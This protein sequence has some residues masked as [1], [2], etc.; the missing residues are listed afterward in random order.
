MNRV[1]LPLATTLLAAC[2]AV[3]TLADRE[4]AAPQEP[5]PATT[6]PARAEE[7]SGWTPIELGAYYDAQLFGADHEVYG[8]RLGLVAQENHAVYGI[9]MT[10][11]FG[12][13]LAGG[14]GLGI[15]LVRH[16]TGGDFVGLQVALG[17]NE[18][19]AATHRDAA[20]WGGQLAVLTNQANRVHGLQVGLLNLAEAVVGVQAGL[21]Q[22]TE[23]LT[24]I[25]MAGLLS[26]VDG[27]TGLQ[28]APVAYCSRTLNG[29][30]IGLFNVTGKGLQIGLVNVNKNG[31][32]PVFPILNF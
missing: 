5:P 3:P 14:G 6:R 30:Q 11:G 8:L 24:G 18:A 20:V 7:T 32:L 25:A 1:H 31:F 15:G 29:A 26:Y 9:D 21:I 12:D 28:I 19:L 27:G 23:H 10:L 4:P 22:G 13:Q 16:R 17:Q 2:T